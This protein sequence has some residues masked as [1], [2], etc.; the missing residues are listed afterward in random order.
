M[1]LTLLS[2]QLA[3]ELIPSDDQQIQAVD[4]D[5]NDLYH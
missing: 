5:L 3:Y 2:K 4:E 1:S